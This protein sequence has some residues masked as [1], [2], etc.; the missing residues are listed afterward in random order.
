MVVYGF[1]VVCGVIVIRASASH[2]F[3]VYDI[4]EAIGF[5]AMMSAIPWGF[6][7]ARRV[8]AAYVATFIINFLLVTQAVAP[9]IA[10][11]A[12]LG[13]LVLGVAYMLAPVRD[14]VRLFFYK[15]KTD[16]HPKGPG[17]NR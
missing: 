13:F 11:F 2:P 3:S 12:I 1:S 17:P 4:F 16:E 7:Y 9:N 14:A 8:I 6:V 10:G 5:G 15:R